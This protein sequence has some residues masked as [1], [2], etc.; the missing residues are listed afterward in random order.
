M[1]RIED[2]LN[3]IN[4]N[5]NR[6]Q[7]K[8][9]GE[10][11]FKSARATFVECCKSVVPKWQDK[12]PDVT[13]NLVRYIVQSKKF[14]GDL[15]K[16]LI[17]VGST[18]VGKTVYLK[19]LSLIMGYSHQFRFKIYTGFEMERIYQLD[20]SHSDAYPLESAMS[21]K[22][23]GIDDLGEE[24]TSIKRYGTEINVGID[25]LTRRHQLY[26]NKGYLTFATSNLNIDMIC[27]KYGQRIE[28]RV[29]EM[30][31]VIGVKGEDLRKT[32]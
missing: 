1:S 7:L 25:T 20:Q 24:H 13:D 22:M 28:S 30:F 18:G 12:H 21:S 3:N 15:T 26:V 17:L 2:Y 29:Y 16:G 31:N 10:E 6:L 9:Y 32:K 5:E 27:K 23:F 4:K 14:E 8:R 19:A 11:K